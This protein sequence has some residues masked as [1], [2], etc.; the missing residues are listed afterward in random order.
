MDPMRWTPALL[1]TWPGLA[2]IHYPQWSSYN[3][4]SNCEFDLP[5]A[6]FHSIGLAEA[7]AL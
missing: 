1:A 7:P 2:C 3:S 4:F 6:A 5:F